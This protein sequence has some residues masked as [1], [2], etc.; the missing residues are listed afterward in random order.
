MIEQDKLLREIKGLPAPEIIS[1][2]QLKPVFDQLRDKWN[3]PWTPEN[4]V[5][6]YPTEKHFLGEFFSVQH[7]HNGWKD[8]RIGFWWFVGHL[9]FLAQA[10]WIGGLAGTALWYRFR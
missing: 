8:Q 7:I 3:P 4:I 10:A 2:E 1:P 5:F 6:T 9:F